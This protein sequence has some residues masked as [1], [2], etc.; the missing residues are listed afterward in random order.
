LGTLQRKEGIW[1]DKG[2]STRKQ[3]RENNLQK[4]RE[5]A[6]NLELREKMRS[7]LVL[8]VRSLGQGLAI[9]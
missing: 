3:S 6:S 5:H 2:K 8:A 9:S 1:G 4:R 7:K